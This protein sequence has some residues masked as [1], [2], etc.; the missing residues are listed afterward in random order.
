MDA[1]AHLA[2]RELYRLPDDPSSSSLH[3]HRGKVLANMTRFAL[4]IAYRYMI[5]CLII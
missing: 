1:P 3:N 2:H 4:S 5:L